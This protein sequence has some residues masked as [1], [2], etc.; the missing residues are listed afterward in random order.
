MAMERQHDGNGETVEVYEN[1]VPGTEATK[2]HDFP[3]SITDGETVKLTVLDGELSVEYKP[4]E[5]VLDEEALGTFIEAFDDPDIAP[6]FLVAKVYREI[7]DSVFPGHAG[8]D[9]PWNKVPLVVRLDYE[10]QGD[11][12]DHSVTMGSYR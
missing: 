5:Y 1:S 12:G 3:V 11:E 7:V 2:T 4:G 9:D 6:E 8:Y 10:R